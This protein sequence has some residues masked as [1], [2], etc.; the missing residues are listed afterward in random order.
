MFCNHGLGDEAGLYCCHCW[1]LIVCLHPPIASIIGHTSLRSYLEQKACDNE[2]WGGSQD[3]STWWWTLL[4]TQWLYWLFTIHSPDRHLAALCALC[5]WC[6][7]FYIK[8]GQ[9]RNV[10][11]SC[12][13]THP[14]LSLFL[15]SWLRLSVAGVRVRM[16][17]HYLIR[18]E[19]YGITAL[20]RDTKENTATSGTTFLI[21]GKRKSCIL[22]WKSK[23]ECEKLIDN[24]VVSS[25]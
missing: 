1:P 25:I 8:F 12:L 4:I 10:K 6:G 2:S 17:D 5:C 24:F 19:H 23:N 9:C 21:K 7:M 13:P 3:V 20:T 11:L 18:T 14:S 15:I 22:L 16:I